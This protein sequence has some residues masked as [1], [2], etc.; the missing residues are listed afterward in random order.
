MDNVWRLEIK[1]L[2]F[3]IF[4]KFSSR[5]ILLT[6]TGKKLQFNKL[7]LTKTSNGENEIIQRLKIKIRSIIII[8]IEKIKKHKH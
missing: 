5:F 7:F 4:S 1:R 2:S 8:K 3:F 6:P